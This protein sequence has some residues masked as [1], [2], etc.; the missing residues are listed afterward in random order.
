VT[1]SARE[2]VAE[3]LEQLASHDHGPH[4]SSGFCAGCIG[5]QAAV[6]I[7]SQE[8][9]LREERERVERLRE[10]LQWTE[11]NFR[12]AAHGKP[13]PDMVENLAFNAA[14]LSGWSSSL[15]A[16]FERTWER[17]RALTNLSTDEI[18]S[19]RRKLLELADPEP[20]EEEA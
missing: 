5:E 11:R 4:F 9:A 16:D 20:T 2:R 12:L 13:V 1:D 14:A 3:R 18:E 19:C 6:L 15:Q 17:V 10:A 8:A 7:R